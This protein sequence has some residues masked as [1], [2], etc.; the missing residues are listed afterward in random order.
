MNGAALAAVENVMITI[1]LAL[2]CSPGDRFWAR[3]EKSDGAKQTDDGRQRPQ[4]SNRFF[5]WFN[6]LPEWSQIL[7]LVG[8]SA[9]LTT[10]VKLGALEGQLNGVSSG[11]I[12]ALLAF[13]PLIVAAGGQA[14]EGRPLRGVLSSISAGV[15]VSLV[16]LFVTD[17]SSLPLIG[18]VYVLGGSLMRGASIIITR[19][20][21]TGTLKK[22]MRNQLLVSIGGTVISFAIVLATGAEM[23]SV[24]QS[25]GVVTL[26]SVLGFLGG[27]I[28]DYSSQRRI[29]SWQIGILKCCGPITSSLISILALGQS[30]S[31][32]QI[33]GVATITA[34]MA[35]ANVKL[36]SR[37][38]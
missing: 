25:I 4:K 19:R 1:I 32:L 13:G 31:V 27:N 12:G 26:V 9:V 14:R 6:K 15:G 5:S 24:W 36:P 7:L 22:T 35:I 30:M 38:K 20:L 2:S 34:A 8:T 37:K 17:R 11:A 18:T 33:C 21:V 3:F 10:G 28:L 29:K 23:T 16:T